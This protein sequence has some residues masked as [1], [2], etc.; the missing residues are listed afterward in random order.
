[1]CCV[2]KVADQ[3]ELW[4]YSVSPIEIPRLPKSLNFSRDSS[5]GR[6]KS[7][8]KNDKHRTIRKSSSHPSINH[9]CPGNSFSRFINNNLRLMWFGV[10]VDN[11]VRSW[12]CRRIFTVSFIQLCIQVHHRSIK[13]RIMIKCI[14]WRCRWLTRAT[15]GNE[16]WKIHN[17]LLL[18]HS[19]DCRIL[20]GDLDSITS[21]ERRGCTACADSKSAVHWLAAAIQS[22]IQIHPQWVGSAAESRSSSET[23]V[24]FKLCQETECEEPRYKSYLL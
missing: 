6:C 5:C 18:T 16:K 9:N 10:F 4:Y 13:P 17:N 15:T 24:R 20:F 8:K 1:M 7:V 11:R 12:Q 22:G 3:T 14:N 21:R 19:D 23:S 2:A